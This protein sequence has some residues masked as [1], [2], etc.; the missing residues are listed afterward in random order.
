[1][2]HISSRIADMDVSKTTRGRTPVPLLAL[3]FSTLPIAEFISKPSKDF[4]GRH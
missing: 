4:I 3:L 2:I 1:M